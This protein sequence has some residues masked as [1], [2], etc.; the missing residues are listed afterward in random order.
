MSFIIDFIQGRSYKLVRDMSLFSLAVA[1]L[2][3]A[4]AALIERGVRGIQQASVKQNLPPAVANGPS[5]TT[6][7]F[8]TRS[9]LDDPVSTGSVSR[10]AQPKR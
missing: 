3:F 1:A 6:T 2:A 8:V 9:V 4:S 5:G 10:Q 7:T